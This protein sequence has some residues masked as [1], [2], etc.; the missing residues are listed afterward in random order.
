MAPSPTTTAIKPRASPKPLWMDFRTLSGG[1]PA[2]SPRAM[3][4]IM[5]A[6][7]ACSFSARMRLS[8][9]A[10]AAAVMRIRYGPFAGIE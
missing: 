3:L 7:N 9:K 6:R 10:I 4:E 1:M 5:R 2:A 8:S